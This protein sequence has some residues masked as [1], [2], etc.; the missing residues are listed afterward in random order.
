VKTFPGGIFLSVGDSFRAKVK[1]TWGDHLP[2]TLMGI[3]QNAKR[4][5]GCLGGGT[6]RAT[7][8]GDFSLLEFKADF[9][10]VELEKC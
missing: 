5:G 8:F 4:L 2:G 10:A 6:L 3:C 7:P 1:G 9:A